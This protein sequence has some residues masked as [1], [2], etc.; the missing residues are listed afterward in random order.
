MILFLTLIRKGFSLYKWQAT[1][2]RR[3]S[4]SCYFRCCQTTHTLLAV[5]FIQMKY[6]RMFTI[7][8]AESSSGRCCCVLSVKLRLRSF[9]VKHVVWVW[10]PP[11][12]R[13]N[14][15]TMWAW[16]YCL[17]CNERHHCWLS[18]IQRCLVYD[19]VCVDTATTLMKHKIF[20]SYYSKVCSI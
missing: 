11:F 4:E 3:Q 18:L 6:A 17:L 13:R 15:L 19:T 7:C 10:L 12:T 8:T 14:R 1:S 5:F 2:W 16:H 20:S 9:N